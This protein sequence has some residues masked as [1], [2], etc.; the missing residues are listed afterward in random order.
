[1]RSVSKVRRVNNLGVDGVE[2]ID[3]NRNPRFVLL[4]VVALDI[5][6]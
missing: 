3:F 5:K 1:V 4:A 6:N 2:L